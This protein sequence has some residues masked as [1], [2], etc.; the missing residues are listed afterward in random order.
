LQALRVPGLKIEEVFKRVRVNVAR[1]SN[2][3]QTPWESSSLTGDL[4]VNVSVNVTTAPV[5]AP[6]VAADREALFW[7]SIKDGTDRAAF[8]AYLKQYPEG[9]FAALARQRLTGVSQQ[10]R[11][12]DPGRFD[13]AWNVTVECPP[14]QGASGYT[15]RLLAQVRDGA[16][17]AQQGGGQAGSG[18][19]TLSGKI[20]P[21]GKASIDA[22]GTVGDP[23]T[24]G[25]R[26]SQGAPYAY[27]VDA[28]FDGARGVGNR[29]EVRPC[30]L[31]FVK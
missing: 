30:S 12:P 6:P 11:A 4:V 20:Q 17:A 15:I 22:R 5:T 27:R 1:R 21:D 29:T 10:T 23:R 16:L 13:G 14:H 3:G 28:L 26:L 25:N 2:G 8:E 24:A 7:M 19:L 18:S 9:T 31:T